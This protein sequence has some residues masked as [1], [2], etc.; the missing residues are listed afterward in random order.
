[1]ATR[2]SH[3][4]DKRHKKASRGK[5]LGS[6]K[7]RAPGRETSKRKAARAG[8]QARKHEKKKEAAGGTEGAKADARPETSRG[9]AALAELLGKRACMRVLWELRDAPLKFRA[10]QQACDGLS[11]STLNQRLAELRE[12]RLVEIEE[13]RGYRLTPQGDELVAQ[14]APLAGWADAWSHRRAQKRSG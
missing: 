1:M 13:R 6:G 14:L 8:K 11:P 3:K 10:L 7:A 4:R 2:P 5:S 9:W 12:A